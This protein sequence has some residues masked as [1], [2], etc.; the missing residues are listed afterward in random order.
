MAHVTGPGEH[1]GSEPI[2]LR[3]ARRA[4]ANVDRVVS[5]PGEKSGEKSGAD[6]AAKNANVVVP[7]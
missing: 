2:G 7:G 6:I 4:N 1:P 3:A 5:A